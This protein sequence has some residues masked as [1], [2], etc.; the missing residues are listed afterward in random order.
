MSRIGA[1]RSCTLR[2]PPDQT[3]AFATWQV[4]ARDYTLVEVETNDG[5]KRIGFSYGGSTARA[6][7]MQSHVNCWSLLS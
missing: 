7:V 3:T 2:V 6:L 1:I 5:C 4:T